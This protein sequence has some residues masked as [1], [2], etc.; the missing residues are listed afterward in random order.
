MHLH[1]AVA[2]R[3]PEAVLLAHLLR[4][5]EGRGTSGRFSSGMPGPLEL[6]T[7]NSSIA[8][9]RRGTD[10]PAVGHGL[11]RVLHQVV[12][13]LAQLPGVD[14]LQPE[15]AIQVGVLQGTEFPLW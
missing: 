1:D 12:E 6:V 8:V 4:G 5:E 11:H 7:V 13:D 2:D 15:R 9:L 14:L 10:G 3:E